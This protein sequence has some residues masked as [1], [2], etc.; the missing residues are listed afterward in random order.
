[1]P[2]VLREAQAGIQQQELGVDTRQHGGVHPRH[3]LG[4]HLAE[5][6]LVARARARR[7]R[8]SA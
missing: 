3:Q 2:G 6:V 7:A 5:H 4:A 8:A 1:M